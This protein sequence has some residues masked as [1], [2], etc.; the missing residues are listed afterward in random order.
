MTYEF[1]LPDIGEGL[2]E[3][4]ILEWN[5]AVGQTVQ[6]DAPVAQ[7]QT[8]KAT[9]E[10]TSPVAGKGERPRGQVGEEP[11]V[12]DGLIAFD[13]GAATGNAPPPQRPA[14]GAP[15]RATRTPGGPDQ[16]VRTTVPPTLRVS[17][18]PDTGS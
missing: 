8:D 6:A 17:I 18:C 4:E 11:R 9:V 12:G 10:I 14:A 2:Q 16:V 15:W 1:R 5:V 13:G 7:I 3:A